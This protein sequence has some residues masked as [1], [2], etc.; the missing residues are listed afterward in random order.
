MAN[1]YNPYLYPYQHG[2]QPPQAQTVVAPTQGQP[3][4]SMGIIWVQGENGAKSY[5]VAP[6]TT[7]LLMDSECQK[8][9]LKSADASGMPMPLRI[10]SYEELSESAKQV[11]EDYATKRDLAALKADILSQLKTESGDVSE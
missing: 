8:F 1:F 11:S 7:V 9:Y 3:N 6:N 4:N 5:L 10:F 2:Y